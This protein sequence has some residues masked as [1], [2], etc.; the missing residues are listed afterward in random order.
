M[1]ALSS[2]TIDKSKLEADL[3][4]SSFY[5]F[6]LRF[7][8]T[9]VPEPLV[10]NWHIEYLCNELQEM[11]ERVFRR[12][13]KQYDLIVNIPPGST[14][15]TIISEML[16]AWCWTRDPTIR[17][18]CGSY[19]DALSIDLAERCYRILESDKYKKLFPDVV[20]AK[21]AMS[22]M[23]NTKGGERVAT[24]TGGRI[25]GLHAHMIIVD[26][27]LN[28]KEALS[29]ALTLQ[30]NTWFD[31]TL[32][33]RMVSKS[34]TPVMLCMQRL[35]QDDVA[36]HLMSLRAAGGTPVRHVC[37]PAELDDNVR[38]RSWRKHYK[39]GLLDPV[40]LPKNILE[41]IRVESTDYVYAGQYQQ[42]PSPKGGGAF[43]IDQIQM[44][45]SPGRMV[46]TWRSW[47]KAGSLGKGAFTVGILMGRSMDGSFWI[48]DVVRGQWE[49]AERE[50]I[51]KQTAIRDGKFVRIVVEQ[52]PGS[53]GK[54]SAAA[55]LK[56][57][58]GFSVKL[59]RPVGDKAMR[60]DPFAAQVNG[61][62]VKMVR[63]IWNAALLSEMQFFPFSKYKDQVDAASMGFAQL[64]GRN[65]RAGAF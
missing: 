7:W 27:P 5:D 11:A 42:R 28:P 65:I 47:D 6:F 18:I 8:P 31:Q 1:T 64:S 13:P 63:G 16:P 3:V 41:D 58:A 22:H 4:K 53:G 23:K 55:T 38:P 40:R 45:P 24:S 17:M 26:D 29:D 59:D 61:G 43:R 14:K 19:G 12:E 35:G 50:R 57:L 48:L 2:L 49:A 46:Q 25:T 54:E 36:G 34:L 44:M 30:A 32:L 62:N 37:L 39:K 51:I 20:L 21:S 33:S 9:I 52:E 60:A 10:A 15:S 56:N